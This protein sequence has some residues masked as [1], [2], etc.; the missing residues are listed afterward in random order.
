MKNSE[1]RDLTTQE[2]V[3][4]IEEQKI[5]LYKLRAQHAVGS[6]EQTHMLKA[7]KRLIARL[8]TELTKRQAQAVA[9]QN[10]NS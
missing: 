6:L 8:K 10:Q 2:L 9:E 1:I 4:Q 3:E 7:T 5:A